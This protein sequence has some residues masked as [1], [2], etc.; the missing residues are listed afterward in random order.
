ME[1]KTHWYSVI[2]YCP[3]EIRGEKVN[4]GLILHSPEEGTVLHAV[5]DES[6]PKVKGVALDEVSQRTFKIHKEIVDFYF[7][8]ITEDRDLLSPNLLEKEFLI[9]LKDEIP[10]NF[11][12]SEPTF[13]LTKDPDQLFESLSKTYIG[14][15]LYSKEVITTD[16]IK[17]NVKTF[18]KQIFTQREWLGTKVKSNVKVHPIKD[19]RSVHF[20][21]DFLFKNGVWNIIQAVPSNSTNEKLVDW[22]SKTNTLIENFNKESD[23]YLVYDEDDSLNQ[24]RTITQMVNVLRSKDKRVR[25]AEVDSNSFELL[26]NKVENEAKQISEYEQ[27]LIAI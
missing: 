9:N 23:Y 24:D 10:S 12:L 6:S 25:A 15:V 11:K 1:R 27:E 17:R 2:Q 13:A 19:L 7:K 18:T 20:N 22:F 21:V 3:N 16:K 8:K 26:C 14:D 5:L 4:I